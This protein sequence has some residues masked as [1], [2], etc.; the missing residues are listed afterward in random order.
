MRNALLA[1]SYQG[2]L[3]R[4]HQNV[5][6][7]QGS[8]IREAAVRS[9]LRSTGI[10]GLSGGIGDI[11]NDDAT[12][13]F[14]S[15]LSGAGTALSAYG[16]A[17]RQLPESLRA[18]NDPLRPIRQPGQTTAQYNAQIETW[19][20]TIQ[21]REAQRAEFTSV[22]TD[23]GFAQLGSGLTSATNSLNTACAQRQQ[24]STPS[25][26]SSFDATFGGGGGGAG[27]AYT[28]PPP[29]PERAGTSI[30]TTTLLIIGGVALAAVL[31]LRK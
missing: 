31:L 22:S 26:G 13:I 28:P 8:G 10:S 12:T 11:C 2:S 9:V 6:S 19:Q 4:Y 21:R 14:S 24:Q 20:Q 27:A 18:S 15:L 7:A 17:A 25:A 1:G 23:A 5:I 16:S 29:P 30:D 3:G